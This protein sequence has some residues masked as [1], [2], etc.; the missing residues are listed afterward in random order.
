MY[1]DETKLSRLLIQR[2]RHFLILEE[3]GSGYGSTH[4][5]VW[6]NRWGQ[7]RVMLKRFVTLRIV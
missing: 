1:I 7:R 3:T 5:L 2:H 4:L 6:G